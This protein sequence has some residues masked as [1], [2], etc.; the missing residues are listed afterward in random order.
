MKDATFTLPMKPTA[1]CLSD[2]VVAT[3]YAI[4]GGIGHYTADGDS[5]SDSAT[6]VVLCKTI[7]QGEPYDLV[8]CVS[9]R[10]ECDA[11]SGG[12]DEY[13]YVI[14][15]EYEPP[16]TLK[17]HLNSLK[18]GLTALLRSDENSIMH[19]DED[20]TKYP[21]HGTPEW[22]AAERIVNYIRCHSSHMRNVSYECPMCNRRH[23]LRLPPGEEDPERVCP[24]CAGGVAVVVDEDED[25]E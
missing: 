19:R 24:S 5:T 11:H 25:E 15:W 2:K 10:L 13:E 8:F 18:P 21:E 20:G 17:E 9:Y 22:R 3:Q 1:H 12:F 14:A 4:L 7:Y 23:G 6:E 16:G